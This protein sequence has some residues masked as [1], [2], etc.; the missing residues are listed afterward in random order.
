MNNAITVPRQQGW[1]VFHTTQAVA[2]FLCEDVH[3]IG[4]VLRAHGRVWV[5]IDLVYL[6]GDPDFKSMPLEYMFLDDGL[7]LMEPEGWWRGHN[8]ETCYP[9]LWIP[10]LEGHMTPLLEECLLYIHTE[11]HGENEHA[12]YYNEV[13][14][15][16]ISELHFLESCVVRHAAPIEYLPERIQL[17][18]FDDERCKALAIGLSK[19]GYKGCLDLTW[20]SLTVMDPTW[21]YS[22]HP[23]FVREPRLAR[24]S[25]VDFIVIPGLDQLMPKSTVSESRDC[26]MSI[27]GHVPIMDIITPLCWKANE[28]WD[29]PSWEPEVRKAGWHKLIEFWHGMKGHDSWESFFEEMCKPRYPYHAIDDS[30]LW[31]FNRNACS[32]VHARNGKEWQVILPSLRYFFEWLEEAVEIHGGASCYYLE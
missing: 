2:R 12:F 30:W 11:A 19:D 23:D 25:M 13:V 17:E 10:K 22:H 7:L 26:L 1:R 15:L 8:Q 20:M 28:G 21:R 32:D 18:S 29:T 16:R 5:R 4:R 9:L 3:L 24:F 6:V 14:D 27:N 31:F